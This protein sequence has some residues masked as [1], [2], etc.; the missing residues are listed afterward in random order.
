MIST[1]GGQC[2]HELKPKPSQAQSRDAEP[3]QDQAD[4]T[5]R[6]RAAQLE[7]PNKRKPG[8]NEESTLPLFRS[9]CLSLSFSFSLSPS[10]SPTLNNLSHAITERKE[11][12]SNTFTF[13]QPRSPKCT[14]KMILKNDTGLFFFGGK[15]KYI[16][17]QYF[18]GQNHLMYPLN[19]GHLP[20][21]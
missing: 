4:P 3:W 10:L 12:D 1:K 7:K 19:R 14:P 5:S 11:L 8:Q 9:L 20:L 13:L 2:K 21:K 17:A 6:S 16:C 15:I 18:K